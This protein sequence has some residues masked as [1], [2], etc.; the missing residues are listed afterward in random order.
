[1]PAQ[2]KHVREYVSFWKQDQLCSINEGNLLLVLRAL[3]ISDQTSDQTRINI[4]G[5][6]SIYVCI[7]GKTTQLLSLSFHLC[8]LGFTCHML[9]FG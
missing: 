2:Y 8:A 9:L 6:Y 1:M 4:A 3:E 5:M 7:P